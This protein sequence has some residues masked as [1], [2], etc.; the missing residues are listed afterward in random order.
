MGEVPLH[1]EHSSLVQPHSAIDIQRHQERNVQ[2]K[3]LTIWRLTALTA[4]NIL[5]FANAEG[6]EL[7]FKII[8]ETKNHVPLSIFIVILP[9]PLSLCLSV[10]LL[11]L[12][13]TSTH[14]QN[15]HTVIVTFCSLN[16]QGC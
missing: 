11:H 8:V 5:A 3:K 4:E 9:P 13:H 16:H 14:P 15:A 6:I 10:S 2:F 7:L 12:P 1:F